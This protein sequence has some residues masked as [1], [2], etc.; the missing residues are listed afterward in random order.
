MWKYINLLL[1]VLFIYRI[2]Q[3]FIHDVDKE[4]I[5]GIEMNVWLYRI[6]Y[7]IIAGMVLYSSYK[8]FKMK[9]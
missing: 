5:F 4:Y 8:H 2:V 7:S 6:I 1:G 9:S 3:S